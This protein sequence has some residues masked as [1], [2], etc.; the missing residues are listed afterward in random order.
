MSVRDYCWH[1]SLIIIMAQTAT[2]YLAYLPTPGT[3][4][5]KTDI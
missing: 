3:S 2:I 5:R 4:S 1:D